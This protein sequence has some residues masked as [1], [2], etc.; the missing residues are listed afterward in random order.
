MGNERGE[1]WECTWLTPRLRFRGALVPFI[2]S[3][4]KRWERALDEL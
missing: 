3:G 4:Q 1:E 2:K